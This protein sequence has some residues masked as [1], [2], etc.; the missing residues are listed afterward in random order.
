MLSTHHL[1]DV[2]RLATPLGSWTMD[3]RTSTGVVH[4]LAVHARPPVGDASGWA[5]DQVTLRSA[6]VGLDGPTVLAGDFNATLDHRPIRELAGR[7]FDDAVVQA[8]SRWEPTWPSAGEV[9]VLGLEVPS[10]L[11]L[12]HVLVNRALHATDTMSV[13]LTGTDH[14]AVVAVLAR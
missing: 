10:L 9:S 5:A 4:L 7:G 11:Q 12:D 1:T 14:R 2:R 3:V 8:R 6:A 13:A